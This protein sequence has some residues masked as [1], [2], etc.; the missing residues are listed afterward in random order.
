MRA[1]TVPLLT[2]VIVTGVLYFAREVLIPLALAVLLT[3]LLSPAVTR[4]ERWKL[5]R[6][7]STLI[8]VTLASA[9]IAGVGYVAVSQGLSLAASLPEYK[10]NITAKVRA[11]RSPSDGTLG[12][13]AKAIKE[14]EGELEKKAAED[15]VAQGDAEPAASQPAAPEPAPPPAAQPARPLPVEVHPP[16]PGA[17]EALGDWLEPLLAPLATAGAVLLF[18]VLMLLQREDLRDRL[19]RLIGRGHLTVTTQALEDAAARVSRYLLMQ[20]IVNVTYGVPVG[21]A[22][23]ML[24]IPNALLWGLLATGLRFVPYAGPVVAAAG[25]ILLALATSEGWSLV[26]WTTAIFLILELVSNNVI[27]PWLYGT[28][29]G[30]SP[31]A[32]VAAAIFWTWLWGPVGLLLATPLT[33]A[34]AVMGRYIPQL[35]FLHVILGDEP[36]LDPD[37]RLYQR[38]LAMDADEA[39]EIAEERLAED[40]LLGLYD[41]VL[42]PALALAEKDRQ[43]DGLDDRRRAFI[44]DTIRRI[45]EE[46]EDPPAAADEASPDEAAA[47]AST[48]AQADAAAQRAEGPGKTDAGKPAL[49]VRHGAR[50][51]PSGSEGADATTGPPV[52]VCIVSANDDADQLAGVMWG[53]VLPEGRF[54]TAVLDADARV[55][56][57]L[58]L[59]SS[60]DARIVCMSALPPTA[61]MH[62]AY[63]CRRLRARFPGIRIVVALWVSGGTDKARRRLQ[64]A[65]VDRIVG[66]LAEGVEAIEHLA[67][68]LRAGPQARPESAAELAREPEPEQLKVLDKQAEESPAEAEVE[69]EDGASR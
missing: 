19:I 1:R 31:I 9:V 50:H 37:A 56:E 10:D 20:L 12:K 41:K 54:A 18:T 68:E 44:V 7:P 21:V 33:V 30:L 15:K 5:G 63:V 26:L 55:G 24:G 3:F 60:R 61:A 48:A 14:I 47:D 28:S 22:L 38:L 13:A 35:A 52:P 62:A 64:A 66:T 25:P 32:V 23:Y 69:A 49:E 8:V 43:V 11:L 59:I 40:G 45:A 16:P 39:T 34:L 2:L 42:I 57:I 58:D 65:G 6:I 51:L 17:L 36:V 27:E 46:S 67:M 4:L 29:T 53:R